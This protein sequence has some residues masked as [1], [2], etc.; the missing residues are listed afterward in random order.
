ML[1]LAEKASNQV[2]SSEADVSSSMAGEDVVEDEVD[3]LLATKDGKIE[4]E[5]DPQL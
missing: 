1:Y 3:R 4:R 5:R 2:D